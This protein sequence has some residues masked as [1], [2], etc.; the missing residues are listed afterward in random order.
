MLA[1]IARLVR[2]ELTLDMLIAGGGRPMGLR[3]FREMLLLLCEPQTIMP[4]K[5]LPPYRRLFVVR[6]RVARVL[7]RRRM[8]AQ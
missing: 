2:G 8:G 6:W 4:L 7:A 3:T 5:L 1:Q